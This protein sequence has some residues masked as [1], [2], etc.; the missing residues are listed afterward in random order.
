MVILWL[1]WVD[2][3]QSQIYDDFIKHQIIMNNVDAR[4]MPEEYDVQWGWGG[5]RGRGCGVLLLMWGWQ[6]CSWS[7]FSMAP[8]L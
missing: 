8:L 1:I 3:E 2:I 7:P 6:V 5:E 4:A